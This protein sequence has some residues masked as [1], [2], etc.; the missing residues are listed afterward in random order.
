MHGLD[1]GS[2]CDSSYYAGHRVTCHYAPATLAPD[3]SV[4]P[5]A[6]YRTLAK[7]TKMLKFN[8]SPSA[9]FNQYF[10]NHPTSYGNE[11]AS[12]PNDSTPACRIS[13]CHGAPVLSQEAD[14]LS[15]LTPELLQTQILAAQDSAELG[16]DTKTRL[17]ALLR[18]SIANLQTARI[19][20][21]AADDYREV[22]IQAPAEAAA[23]RATRRSFAHRRRRLGRGVQA[24]IVTG[25]DRDA[26]PGIA[27]PPP[28]R[29]PATRTTRRSGAR[30]FSHQSTR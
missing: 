10:E 13:S 17:I 23:I 27:K 20:Q 9:P 14:S 6:A 5:G 24:G 1:S 2:D 19:N 28:T 26:R 7:G 21:Q 8:R 22:R 16:E 12:P 25:R 29:R 4:E 11:C 18:Q 30:Y 3:G 15:R